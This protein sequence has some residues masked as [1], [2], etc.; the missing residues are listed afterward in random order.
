MK[1][2][3]IIDGYTAVIQYD[4]EIGLLRGEFVGLN[5]GADFYA[6]DVAGLKREGK[7]SLQVFLEMC[8]QDGVAP[9][10]AFS[11]KFNVRVSPALHA[12]SALAAVAE[13]SA[14]SGT[15][16]PTTETG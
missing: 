11:G 1:N 8:A 4:P 5:G 9:R 13:R 12:D 7:I 6:S 16:I 15:R 14:G 2:T 3:M 10:R